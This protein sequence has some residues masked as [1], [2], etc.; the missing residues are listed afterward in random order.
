MDI[1][2]LVITV[3]RFF[4][5]VPTLR[6]AQTL[7]VFSHTKTISIIIEV[8]WSA[9]LRIFALVGY[10]ITV[11]IYA[12]TTDFCPFRINIRIVVITVVITLRLCSEITF[13]KAQALP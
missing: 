3:T 12:I 6:T 1:G 7:H 9:S 13:P 8:I 5:I 4:G 10:A 11:V 2:V